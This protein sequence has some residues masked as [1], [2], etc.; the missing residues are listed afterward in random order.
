MTVVPFTMQLIVTVEL[1]DWTDHVRFVGRP[2]CIRRF[3]PKVIWCGNRYEPVS[4]K[5]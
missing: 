1:H 5:R 3:A 2:D 4:L